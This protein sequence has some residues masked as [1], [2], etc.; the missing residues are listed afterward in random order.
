MS[1]PKTGG[2]QI[3]NHGLDPIVSNPAFMVTAAPTG[4]LTVSAHAEVAIIVPQKWITEG[5]LTMGMID[6]RGFVY[7]VMVVSPL[8]TTVVDVGKIQR[9]STPWN[10]MFFDSINVAGTPY[11]WLLTVRWTCT[12]GGVQDGPEAKYN[13]NTAQR[14][15]VST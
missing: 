11:T 1:I 4:A 5:L 2:A 3:S 13:Q 8:P 9:F 6:S 12:G 10:T 14:S 15:Q 7:S